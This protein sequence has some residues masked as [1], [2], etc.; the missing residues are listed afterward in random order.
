[1]PPR[2]RLVR[3]APLME[4]IQAYLDVHDWLLWLSEELNT[5]DWEDFAK[6]YSLTIGVVFN[7]VY[8]VAQA[9]TT[10]YSH[11]DDIL[12]GDASGPGWF[13]WFCRL[14][15][16]VLA[17]T[18]FFNGF[19]TFYKTRHYRLFEQPIDTA[20]STP[21]ARRVR[22]DSSP[23]AMSPLRYFQNLL[24]SNS[25]E[26]RAH[27]DAGRD[28]WEISVWDPNPLC[29]DIFCLFSP[30]H[31]VLYWMNLPVLPMDQ[32]PSVTVVTTIAIG[33]FL[34]FSLWFLRSSFAAQIRDNGVIQREV[35]HEYDNKFVHPS[36]RKLYRDV[37]IQAITKKRNR[38]SSVG[39]RGSSDDLA[40]QITT[41]TPTIVINRSFRTNPNPAYA[42]QYDPDGLNSGLRSAAQTPSVR[43][44]SA[45]NPNYSTT[46]TATGGDFSS[47]IR[48]SQ[49]PNPF[50]ASRKQS[51]P[52]FR[53]SATGGDGG[54][55][56]V[57]SHANSPLRKSA[58]T[59]FPRDRDD[60]SRDS[61]GGYGLERRTGTPARREGSPLK[62]SS[63][64]GAGLGSTNDRLDR[65][66]A[67]NNG[68][69]RGRVED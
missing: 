3:K 11:T 37:G 38:D 69:S 9:N 8:I 13:T 44:Y 58:S 4:R 21:A 41:Y 54:S 67:V 20:P 57:F 17:G 36:T 27:P 1:M 6:D 28:V 48:S 7:L 62:R 34:S 19:F 65:A 52:Q 56:G 22:V 5:N 14:A 16:T 18:A 60:R 39:V 25:A 50:R 31:V 30:L 45:A 35:L 59:N 10:D 51:Q 32:R 61:L 49:T 46:S 2:E 47:P 15:A 33:A 26:S 53:P 66:E 55:L 29:L 23:A 68:S 64:P 40:S 43:P 42:S 12:L 63:M 24:G